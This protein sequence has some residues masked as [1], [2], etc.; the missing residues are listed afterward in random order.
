[1]AGPSDPRHFALPWLLLK[2]RLIARDILMDTL[3]SFLLNLFFGYLVHV[4]NF[5]G[6]GVQHLSSLW[7]SSHMIS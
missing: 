1:M 6:A 7:A 2:L 4:N 5:G 3:Q